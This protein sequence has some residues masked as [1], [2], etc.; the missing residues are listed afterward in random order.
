MKT[1]ELRINF[2]FGEKT[3]PMYGDMV[4]PCTD[5]TLMGRYFDALVKEAEASAADYADYQVERIVFTGG[6]LNLAHRANW[7]N[8]LYQIR[9]CFH[10]QKAVSMLHFDSR[11]L[12]MDDVY[13]SMT[14]EF[15]A[16]D[17]VSFVDEE[18]QAAGFAHCA[19]DNEKADMTFFRMRSR[20]YDG[21]LCCGLPTQTPQSFLTT[22]KGAKGIFVPHISVVPYGDVAEEK[23]AEY[24]A[25]ARE[26][27]S[28]EGYAEYAPLRFG[29]E[30]MAFSLYQEQAEEYL[31]LGM[32]AQSF[33]DGMRFANTP[34]LG[35]YIE[36]SADFT[37]IMIRLA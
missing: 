5:R 11:L 36:N 32:G 4:L 14:S 20:R 9:K 12:S 15:A 3:H 2:P 16:V 23:M 25:V 17:M 31:G 22:L 10:A 21:V 30:G 33:V 26:Y 7:H 6:P 28:A 13:Q 18:L 29:R 19:K 1:I 35:N 8:A 37:K 34:D 27:L 24:A